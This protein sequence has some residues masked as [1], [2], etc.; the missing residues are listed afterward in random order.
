MKAFL[1][2]FFLKTLFLSLFLLIFILIGTWIK[3][4]TPFIIDKHKKEVVL[5]KNIEIS[6]FGDSEMHGALD[7][8][9]IQ[10]K[11]NRQTNN[12]A[13]GGQTV[14]MN[15][16]KARDIIKFNPKTTVI[17]DYGSND[18]SYRGDMIRD[19]V[20]LFDEAAYR[21]GISN[22]FQ[23]MK[24]D[25]LYFFISNFPFITIQSIFSGVT[26]YNH[27]L[28]T[29]IDL[30]KSSKLDEVISNYDSTIITLDSLYKRNHI[31]EENYPFLKLF[32]L[33]KNHPQTQ[34][35]LVNP[36]EYFMNKLVYKNDSLKW[37]N[38][39]KE[40]KK[41]ENVSVINLR[42]YDLEKS[43]FEDF[44]HLTISGNK[45]FSIKL[46]I[47]IDSILFIKKQIQN[48]TNR[49]LKNGKLKKTLKY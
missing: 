42:N 36:P 16:L 49:N 31:I 15:V 12:L 22:N 23:F 25:E 27:V 26:G 4:N 13:L 5:K 43:D 10:K 24:L 44:S 8:K 2:R 28:H 14:F 41:L 30:N 35:I 45:K 40:F 9:I 6:I 39:I 47:E 3:S 11:L 34:F 48:T 19:E 20:D 7:S 37:L 46:S 17:F 1:N 38:N 32:R 33:I 18:V 21:F 29:G